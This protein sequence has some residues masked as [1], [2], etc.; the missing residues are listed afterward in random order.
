MCILHEANRMS[1]NAEQS[2]QARWVTVAT[3]STGFEADMARQRLAA[4]GI[5]VLVE[6][7][8]PGIFGASFQG[9]VTGG[10][11]LQVPSP[12]S[13]WAHSLLADDVSGYDADDELSP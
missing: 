6:S 9:A 12:V 3:F 8:A 7:N 13:E 1:N 4:E 11:T 10:I 5:P 2:G